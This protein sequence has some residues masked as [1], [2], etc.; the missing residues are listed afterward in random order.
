[1]TITST[2]YKLSQ[3]YFGLIQQFRLTTF[4]EL[5]LVD[6]LPLFLFLAV[7]RVAPVLFALPLSVFQAFLS[8]LH[9]TLLERFQLFL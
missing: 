6:A 8:F 5:L 3:L 4:L 1:M 9:Q 2:D 7:E